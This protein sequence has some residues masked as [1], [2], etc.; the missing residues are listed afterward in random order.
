MRIV[1]YS[2][3]LKKCFCLTFFPRKFLN[4]YQRI[5]NQYFLLIPLPLLIFWE[6]NCCSGSYNDFQQSLM[7]IVIRFVSINAKFGIFTIVGLNGTLIEAEIRTFKCA[8]AYFSFLLLLLHLLCIFHSRIFFYILCAQGINPRQKSAEYKPRQN[9]CVALSSWTICYVITY[10]SCACV[11]LYFYSINM[12]PMPKSQ[13]SQGPKSQ[14]S[15]V[16]YQN[17]PTQW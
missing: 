5:W 13:Q 2:D 1:S 4:P 17:T 10:L 8:K 6:E 7:Y 15:Q 12:L 3:T 14:Q 9:L 11:H 16:R